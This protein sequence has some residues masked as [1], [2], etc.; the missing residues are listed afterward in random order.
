MQTTGSLSN[1][2][3][4]T[5]VV[6][7]ILTIVAILLSIM[8]LS[9]SSSQSSSSLLLSPMTLTANEAR[10][11]EVVSGHAWQNHGEE[12]NDA[13]K[14][15]S[16]NGTWKSFKTSGFID[17]RGNPVNSNLWICFNGDDFFAI[18][19]TRF[20]KEGGNQIARLV[21]AYKIAKDIFPTIDDFI[22]YISVKWGALE[23]NYI[24]QSG[25]KIFLSP[26]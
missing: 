21:T 17:E 10:I 2:N 6:I 25:E 19:T 7:L 11:I 4:S 24:I 22:Q 14:C 13:I 18:V 26:K 23:I 3:P 12:V 9:I 20:I 8:G 16:D 5:V 1:K 15:L